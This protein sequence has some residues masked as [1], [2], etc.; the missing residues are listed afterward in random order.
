MFLNDIGHRN[1]LI[2]I[3][4]LQL[5]GKYWEREVLYPG[6]YY[7]IKGGI[8][9]LQSFEKK[10]PY[11]LKFIR[12]IGKL[13]SIEDFLFSLIILIMFVLKLF[14]NFVCQRKN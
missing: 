2:V 13:N 9:E 14:Q 7:G 5:W 3:D 6:S 10:M 1:D 11:S 12:L 8:Y 4:L